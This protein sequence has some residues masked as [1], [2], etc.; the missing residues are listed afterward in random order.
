M[1]R[2]AFLYLLAQLSIATLFLAALLGKQTC[3]ELLT[4][5]FQ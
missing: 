5:A 3:M 4:S 2:N 1:I